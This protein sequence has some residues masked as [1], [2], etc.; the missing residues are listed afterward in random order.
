MKLLGALGLDRILA[1]NEFAVAVL[2]ELLYRGKLR[3]G[4]VRLGLIPERRGRNVG[5]LCHIRPGSPAEILDR[6]SK[7]VAEADGVG[8]MPAIHAERAYAVRLLGLF[9]LDEAGVWSI[10]DPELLLVENLEV[11]GAQYIILGARSADGRIF[12]VAVHVELDF[13]FAPPDVIAAA[14]REVCA[15]IVSTALDAV[16]NR[17]ERALGRVRAA[18]LGVEI[19]RVIRNIAQGVVDLVKERNVLLAAMLEGDA[20]FLSERHGPEAAERLTR[21]DAY[22]LGRKR[23]P[24]LVGIAEEVAQ[25]TLYRRLLLVIPVHSQNEA[26]PF[27]RAVVGHR[28]P[29][30]L[31]KTGAFDIH[32][33]ERLAGLYRDAGAHLPALAEPVGLG[34]F[35]RNF[36]RAAAALARLVLGADRPRLGIRQKAQCVEVAG[37][38]AA[39]IFRRRTSADTKKDTARNYGDKSLDNHRP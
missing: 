1:R 20:G 32:E 4:G 33:L 7:V 11:V 24:L 38:R 22:D 5:V 23:R 25:R 13:A 8:D 35:V 6:Y 29:H 27:E 16:E 14:P 28:K 19:R 10:V 2:F 34:P 26:A 17:M 3:E 39:G 31:D 9:G 30:I 18:E 37:Y 12:R 15:R 21:A 36:L